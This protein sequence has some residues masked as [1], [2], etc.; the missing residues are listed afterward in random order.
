[1]TNALNDNGTYDFFLAA[2]GAVEPA[3]ESLGE[4][5]AV[6]VPATIAYF[7]TGIVVLAVGFVVLDLL[8]PGNLRELVF[9]ENRAGAAALASAQQIALGMIIV[10]VIRA[11]DDRLW[12]GIAETLIYGAIGIVAQGLALL[13]LEALVPGRF[14]DVVMDAKLRPRAVMAGVTLVVIGLINAVALS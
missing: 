10:S 2:R 9:V 3:A 7:A 13:V 5:L 14:R 8:T 1:M 6:G 4:Q 12:I 11:S